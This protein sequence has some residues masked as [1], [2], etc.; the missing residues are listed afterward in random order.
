[1]A[2][3]HRLWMAVSW[4]LSA[5]AWSTPAIE[6]PGLSRKLEGLL[7]PLARSQLGETLSS[8]SLE[9]ARADAVA[10]ALRQRLQ[11]LGYL[12]ASVRAVPQPR[13]VVF[14]VELGRRFLVDRLRWRVLSSAESDKELVTWPEPLARI[15]LAT[16]VAGYRGKP[17]EVEKLAQTQLEVAEQ[18]QEQ[19][20]AFAASQRLRLRADALTERVNVTLPLVLG[21]QVEFGP[22]SVDGLD[23]LRQSFVLQRL[24]WEEGALFSPSQVEATRDALLRTGLF[25]Q[26]DI[27]LASAPIVEAMSAATKGVETVEGPQKPLRYPLLLSVQERKPRTL[28]VGVTY[29]TTEGVGGLFGWENRNI[30]GMGE[31]LA[32]DLVVAQIVQEFNLSMRSPLNDR[33]DLSWLSYAVARRKHVTSYLERSA[34]LAALLEWERDRQFVLS[35]GLKVEGL[36]VRDSPQNGQNLIGSLPFF[37]NWTNW[38]DPAR[39]RSGVA[40]QLRASPTGALGAP[41][42]AFF[43]FRMA[44]SASARMGDASLAARVTLG[45]ILGASLESIPLPLRFYEGSVDGLRGYRYQT[46]SPLDCCGTP[47]GGRSL[48]LFNAELRAPLTC[49]LELIPFFDL[50]N[51]YASSW[52]SWSEGW[53]SALGLGVRWDSLLGPLRL[54]VALPLNRRPCLDKPFSIYVGVG[55]SF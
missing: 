33:P 36:S 31:R 28:S 27:R 50:G 44:A 39:P 46:V 29:A 51:V 40:L 54:D 24:R 34:D 10:E 35:A 23:R 22:T 43:P 26:V 15:L 37:L 38:D 4:G 52:P 21:P 19:G 7:R 30:D 55:Q 2:Q 12:E 16:D 13:A 53:R 47:I 45:S 20:Y 3:M 17:L 8:P 48:F 6:F 14:D 49:S 18:L 5:W 25:N 1:M 41:S 11:S 9:R 32:L 42:S